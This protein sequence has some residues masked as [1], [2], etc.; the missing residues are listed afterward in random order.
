MWQG[1]G[2]TRTQRVLGLVGFIVAAVAD[3]ALP[4]Q[5]PVVVYTILGG[6]LGLDVLI[7]VLDKLR[8]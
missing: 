1:E 2:W 6:L 8:R 7:E 5:V 4:L 3:S